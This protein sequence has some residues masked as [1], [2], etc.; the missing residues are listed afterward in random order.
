MLIGKCNKILPQ[1]SAI[2]FQNGSLKF[3]KEIHREIR[4]H[5]SKKLYKTDSLNQLSTFKSCRVHLQKIKIKLQIK[6]Q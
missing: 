1:R 6:M 2:H 3:K 5:I 4:I